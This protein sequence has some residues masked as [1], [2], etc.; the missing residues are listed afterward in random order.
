MLF[1]A[2][3]LVTVRF[4][5][6]LACQLLLAFACVTAQASDGIEIISAK[7]ESSE[8]G[9]R[10]DT[11][12]GFDLN[13]SLELALQKG[14]H[15]YFTTEIELTRPRWWWRD[16]RAVSL[17]RTVELQYDPLTRAYRVGSR[18]SLQQT[19][20]TLDDALFEIR[21]PGRWLIAP[22]GALKVGETYNVTLKMYMDREFFAKPL[23]VDALNNSDLRLTSPKISFPYRAE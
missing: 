11:R 6:L 18:G 12:Y 21:R 10:L 16:D 7:I 1:K 22:R 3:A 4:F 2:L 14:L 20:D 23:Q 5:R 17:K 15:L 8:D 13:P 19:K 9:Y